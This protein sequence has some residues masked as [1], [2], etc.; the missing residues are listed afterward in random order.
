[1][2]LRNANASAAHNLRQADNLP[3]KWSE[4]VVLLCARRICHASIPSF[5]EEV[6][7]GSPYGLRCAGVV[8]TATL[9]TWQHEDLEIT[10][11]FTALFTFCDAPV[12]VDDIA[13]RAS[14]SIQRPFRRVFQGHRISKRIN[15]NRYIPG[16]D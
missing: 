2:E 3:S 16:T 14:A 13:V 11:A 8:C 10:P 12:A 4:S 9:R 1:V 15:G 5:L 7:K 6:L